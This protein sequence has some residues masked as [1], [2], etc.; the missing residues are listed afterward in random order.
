MP[1][2]DFRFYLGSLALNFSATV[3]FRH[4]ECFER[5]PTPEDFAR[6]LVASELVEELPSPTARH[7]RNALLLR[8]SVFA[9]GEALVAGRKPKRIDVERINEAA[10][11]PVPAPQLDVVR[12]AQRV[13]CEQP[14]PSALSQIA[15]DAINVF[16]NMRDRLSQCS[17]PE[18]RA[19][20]LSHSR[21]AERRWCS[22]TT[23]GNRAK[24]VAFRSRRLQLA[25][26]D[27]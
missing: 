14:T 17:D 22:M 26:D 20:M 21:G 13:E 16:A 1:L 18:C 23:C 4:G 19:L 12:L 25:K 2:T 9:I 10:R 3:A 7:Y 6:W 27:T 15:R 5:I 8:E 11:R 24:S